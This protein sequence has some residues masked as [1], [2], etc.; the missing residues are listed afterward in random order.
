MRLPCR[1]PLDNGGGIVFAGD[2]ARG[3]T[4]MTRKGLQKA[5]LRNGI[6]E[7]I[8]A[9]RELE[10]QIDA[11]AAISNLIV[12][13]L[14]AGGKLLVAGNGG[15]AAEAMHMAEEF[16]GRFRT[17]RVALPAIGLAADGTALTCIGNDFG[18]EFIFSRQV[19]ALGRPGDVLI[20]FSTSGNSRNL[21][22]AMEA[23]RAKKMKT[24]CIL[25]RD[26]GQLRGRGTLEVVI[27]MRACARIQEAHQILM[28]L[29]L[30]EVEQVFGLAPEPA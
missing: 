30:E 22:A 28:H 7:S 26:G 6:G 23:A 3:K 24:V 18:F 15:S 10:K 19:Q 14:K 29:V 9:A 13:S 11:V 12:A 5:R 21:I 27:P 20:L 2:D 25:G 1:S 4:H 8:A 17:N 16:T